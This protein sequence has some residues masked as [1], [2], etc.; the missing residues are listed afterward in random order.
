M[1][2]SGIPHNTEDKSWW[3]RY[4]EQQEKAFVQ[5]VAPQIGLQAQIN[6]AKA[7]DKYAPDLVV[8]GKIADLKVQKTPFFTAQRYGKNPSETVTLNL[9]DYARYLHQYPTIEIYFY[10][11]WQQ[12][13]YQGLTVQP[14]KGVWMTDLETITRL[15]ASQKAPL[16]VYQRRVGDKL[17][18]NESFLLSLGDLCLIGELPDSGP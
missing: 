18:A 7:A 9:K 4:G 5:T 17:N 6:P 8:C 10:V 14:R 3:T 2:N 12:L 1:R 11:H 15:K 16:H 13:A